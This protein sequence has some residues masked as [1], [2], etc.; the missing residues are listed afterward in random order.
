MAGTSDVTIGILMDNWLFI[1]P[2]FLWASYLLFV[3]RLQ[4]QSYLHP[5]FDSRVYVVLG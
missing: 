5:S 4:R 2:G 3:Q 1:L